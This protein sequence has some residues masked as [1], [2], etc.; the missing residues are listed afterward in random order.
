MPFYEFE[1]ANCQRKGWKYTHEVYRPL[2]QSGEPY[3]C[4]NCRNKTDRIYSG[5]VTKEFVEYYSKGKRIG[6]RLQD[7][8]F[9]RANGRVIT[10]DTDGWRDIK[11]MAKDG[12]HRTRLSQKG[13]Y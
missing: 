8:R 9:L 13:H 11:K 7:K 2:S 4:P 6:T 5:K 1:C 10:Q 12:Q 3:A